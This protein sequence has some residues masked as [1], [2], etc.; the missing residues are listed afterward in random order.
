M[1]IF[2]PNIEKLKKKKNIDALVLCMKHR[3]PVV[4]YRAFMALAHMPGLSDE[5]I[6]R[7]KTRL[8]DSDAGVR[9]VATLKFVGLGEE[10]RAENLRELITG[11]ARRDKIDLLRIIAGRGANIDDVILEAIVLAL[12]DRK[13]IVRLEAIKTA[14]AVQ[15]PHLVA[16]LAPF[17]RSQHA[18]VRSE[19]VLALG[20]IADERSVDYLIGFLADADPLVRQNART[21]LESIDSPRVRLALN[22][23]RFMGL[24]AGMNGR[25]PDRRATARTIGVEGVREALPL[26]HNACG[27]KFK[28][29]RAEAARSIAVFG[30]PL[31]VDFAAR[32]LK[33][34]FYDVRLEAVR[35]LAKIGGDDALKAMETALRDKNKRIREETKR[36]LDAGL[37]R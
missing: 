25:E 33:D 3:K 16:N 10:I 15:S 13:P 23:S 6:D 26:L 14:G 35:A 9:T 31:S 17:L 12:A 32:L 18:L 37:Y 21:C 7:M 20:K 2:T 1:G 19:L 11:A 27:D 8:Y 22:D 5:V 24:V 4:R 29:V 34:R 28:E 30:D 36:I